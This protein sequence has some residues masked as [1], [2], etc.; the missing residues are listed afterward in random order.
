MTCQGELKSHAPRTTDD[1]IES[2]ITCIEIGSLLHCHRPFNN[3]WEGHAGVVAM[4][5]VQNR[6]VVHENG[7]GHVGREKI[8]VVLSAI[9]KNL[10]S[11]PDL[12]IRFPV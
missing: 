8:S 7:A 2:P 4:A 3:N 10:N 12:S 5:H 9:I 11:E 1:T 6:T